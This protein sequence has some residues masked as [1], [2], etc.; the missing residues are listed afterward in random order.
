MLNELIK[1][2]SE[3][4]FRCDSEERLQVDIERL[5]I[6][7]RI[8][9]QREFRLNKRDRIDFYFE[10]IKLGLECKIK[11]SLTPV[12]AQLLRY[13]EDERIETLLLVTTRAA[14]ADMPD[15]LGGKRVIVVHQCQNGF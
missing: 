14:I 5:L 13:A 15:T 12:M 10:S 7:E 8:E 2:L 9:H 3:T 1:L 4:Q 6:L 11:G